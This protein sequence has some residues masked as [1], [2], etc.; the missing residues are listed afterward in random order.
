ALAPLRRRV[1]VALA[2][3]HA[4]PSPRDLIFRECRPLLRL[5]YD[6]VDNALIV[7]LAGHILAG[8]RPPAGRVGEHGA[9]MPQSHE[10]LAEADDSRVLHHL[11][12]T[13]GEEQMLHRVI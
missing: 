5:Q 2:L 6:P 8:A 10:R 12:P 7:L 13:E 11:A 9:L 4:R 3:G 1:A